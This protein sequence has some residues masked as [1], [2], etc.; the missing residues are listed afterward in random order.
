MNLVNGKP[1]SSISIFDRGFLYGDGVF[2]TILV[3]NKDPKNIKLH[4]KRIKAGCKAL[5]IKNF[6]Q[7]TLRSHIAKAISDQKNCI[8]N[9]NITRGTVKKRGYN[10]NIENISPN[11]IL[12]TSKMEKIPKSYNDNGIKTKF[13]KTRLFKTIEPLESIKHMNRLTQVLATSELSKNY[14]ELIMCD[15]DN[16][17]IEGTSSNIFFVKGMNFYTPKIHGNS[18]EGVMRSVI[19]NILKKNKYKI[20]IKKINMK[21]IKNYDG[22][23]FC[24]SIRLIWNIKDLSGYKYKINNNIQS[25][26][27]LVDNEI[28]K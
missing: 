13:S 22:A 28:Y 6:N 7:D 25:L 17:I 14:P 26:I 3:L 16:N 15:E 10:I 21:D 18:V 8:L 12:T 5:K 20:N 2:E 11:I 27:K 24:N 19:I 9:I 23:F 1:K 4:I